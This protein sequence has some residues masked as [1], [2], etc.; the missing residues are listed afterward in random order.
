[1]NQ[2]SNYTENELSRIIV[3]AAF[4]IHQ[5]VGPGLLE[6]VYE[7][8]LARELS[9]RGLS[10]ARQR[11]IAIRYGDLEFDEGFRADLIVNE[12][13]IVEVKSVE[14]AVPQHKRQ[15]LTYLRFSGLRLGVLINFWEPY[16][17]DAAIRVVNGLPDEPSPA[18]SESI[19]SHP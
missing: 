16:F 4:H 18:C 3:D 9:R 10:V 11:A 5:T 6:S 7:A 8:I 19:G 1:M 17:K 2:A 15:L 12:T 14:R 13:V